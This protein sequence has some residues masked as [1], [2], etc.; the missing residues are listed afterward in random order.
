M[1]TSPM[2]AVVA[3]VI[4][5]VNVALVIVVGPVRT[6]SSADSISNLPALSGRVAVAILPSGLPVLKKNGVAPTGPARKRRTR[7]AA[8]RDLT[9]VI[10]APPGYQAPLTALARWT[11]WPYRM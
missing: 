11:P 1:R 4:K 5:P 7:I 10:F 9:R 2:F 3:P 6:K 8:G